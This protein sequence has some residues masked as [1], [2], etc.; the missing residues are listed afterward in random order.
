MSYDS[1]YVQMDKLCENNNFSYTNTNR[2]IPTFTRTGFLEPRMYKTRK[3]SSVNTRENYED[4]YK[5][6][7]STKWDMDLTFEKINHM[8]NC[9][10]SNNLN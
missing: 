10:K 5:P 9:Y 7:S 4:D 3:T 2:T 8:K 1:D 6:T